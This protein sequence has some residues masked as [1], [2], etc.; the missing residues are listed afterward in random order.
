MAKRS[1]PSSTFRISPSAVSADGA[2]ALAPFFD[3]AFPPFFGFASL[4]LGA[5]AAA[6]S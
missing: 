3:A 5:P 2:P 6:S 1:V 4:A